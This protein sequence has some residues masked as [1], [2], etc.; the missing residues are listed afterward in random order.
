M[1]AVAKFAQEQIAPLVRKMESDGKLDAGVLKGLFDNGLMGVDI[2]EEYSGTG[3][4]FMASILVVEEIAKVDPAVSVI[5]DIQNTLINSLINRLGTEEQKKKYLTALAT[6]SVSFSSFQPCQ[7]QLTL[8]PSR[9]AVSAYP[10][11][12]LAPMPSLS[13]Q[14][15][16]KKAR[17]TFSMEPKCGSATLT[18]LTSSWLW[19]TLILQKATEASRLSS[20]RRAW[21]D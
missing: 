20:S 14:P 13:R 19:P 15:L 18:S 17:I 21:K 2:P 11:Q 12:R 7:Q 16:R 9:L 6:K 10:S 8:F 1:C 3:S 4:T 5:V